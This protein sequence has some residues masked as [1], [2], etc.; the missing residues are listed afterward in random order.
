MRTTIPGTLFDN[1]ICPTKPKASNSGTHDNRLP[2]SAYSTQCAT[3]G[4]NAT[5][6]K[7]SKKYI[8]YITKV[9]PERG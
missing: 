4:A 9:N 6:R 8:T 7:R 3:S 2:N 1:N 5:T